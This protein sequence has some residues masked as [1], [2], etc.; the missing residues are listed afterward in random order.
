MKLLPLVLSVAALTLSVRAENSP[1]HMAVELSN[2]VTSPPKDTHDK[3]QTRSLKITIDNNS[4]QSFDGLAVKYWFVGHSEGSHEVKVLK[5]GERKSTLAPRGKDVVESEVATTHFVEEHFK[6]AAGARGGGKA[7]KIPAS[8][9]KMTAY[10]VRVMRD[11]KVL[12]E[13]YSEPSVKT[14]IDNPAAAA[15]AKPPVKK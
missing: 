12:A 13:Y 1:V 15:P 8:G 4:T 7:T 14:L 5:E 6:A 10:A 11:T 9:E 3:T 2:K